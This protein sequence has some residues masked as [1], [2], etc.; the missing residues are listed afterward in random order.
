[1]GPLFL[2]ATGLLNQTAYSNPDA[3][4]LINKDEST[5]NSKFRGFV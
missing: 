4:Y 1:M 5:R 2:E 3:N